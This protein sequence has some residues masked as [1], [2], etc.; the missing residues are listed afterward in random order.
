M[1]T[2]Q[3]NKEQNSLLNIKITSLIEEIL[4]DKEKRRNLKCIYMTSYEPTFIYDNTIQIII[5][6]VYTNKY[7]FEKDI[8]ILNLKR[9]PALISEEI[10][11]KTG[12]KVNINICSDYE[13]KYKRVLS[14]PQEIGRTNN[15]NKATILYSQDKTY[16]LI[17]EKSKYSTP[18]SEYKENLEFAPP[19]K[20]TLSRAR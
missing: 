12:I 13:G 17:K 20:L 10:F 3:I 11:E 19:I 7:Y 5:T 2:K 6:M 4:Q 18:Q 15:L 16:E 8:P 9:T 14:N 1:K